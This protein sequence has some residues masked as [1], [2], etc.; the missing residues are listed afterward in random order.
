V[1]DGRSLRLC[2]EYC[3]KKKQEKVKKKSKKKKVSPK[4][5]CVTVIRK[6]KSSVKKGGSTKVS[7]CNG[8]IYLAAPIRT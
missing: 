8:K 6:E 1:A 3:K 4:A 7:G 2:Q 5:G